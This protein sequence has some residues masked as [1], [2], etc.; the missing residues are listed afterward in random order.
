MIIEICK[1]LSLN[2]AINVFTPNILPILRKSKVKVHILDGCET[3]LNRI[4]QKL[5]S[6][7]II[8]LYL[9]TDQYWLN[10]I[11]SS[12]SIFEKIHSLTLHNLEYFEQISEYE[13]HFPKL[14]CLSFRYNNDIGFNIFS[15]IFQYISNSIKRFEIHCNGSL[16]THYN[17]EQFNQLYIKN[18]S[19][20]YFLLDMGKYS[21]ISKNECFR[22]YK[23]C[24]LKI[25]IDLI[26]YMINIQYIRLIINSL[27]LEKIIRY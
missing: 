2:D 3:Y 15:N 8:S 1:Y 19:I 11:F 5:E 10:M 17:I 18:Y 27:D 21:S 24:F 12:I 25:T 26:E 23:S 7:Q 22:N 20:K 14:T 16:C 13:I 6:E 4:I 9:N